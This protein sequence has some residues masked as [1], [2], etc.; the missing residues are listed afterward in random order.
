MRIVIG[1]YTIKVRRTKKDL[2]P[3]HAGEWDA[4]E[5]LIRL[6]PGLRGVELADTFVHEIVEAI[7]AIRDLQLDH[8]KIQVLGTDL[9]HALLSAK[10]LKLPKGWK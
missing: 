2:D 9:A 7:N 6:D 3:E 8:T 4:A 10:V 5:S 1:P